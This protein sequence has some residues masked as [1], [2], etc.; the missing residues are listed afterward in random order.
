L[1]LPP[2]TEDVL[3]SSLLFS[4]SS[5][6][7]PL[8]T[9]K[10]LDRYSLETLHKSAMH[11]AVSPSN[12]SLGTEEELAFCVISASIMERTEGTRRPG[13]VAVEGPRLK[14]AVEVE[15]MGMDG[16]EFR[17]VAVVVVIE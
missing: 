13:V 9:R 15:G 16:V 14:V 2:P 7:S 17:L 10:F 1:P 4:S 6:K 11:P 12:S 3:S 8:S 5:A